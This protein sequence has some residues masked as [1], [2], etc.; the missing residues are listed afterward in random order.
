MW[1]YWSCVHINL[2]TRDGLY[3]DSIGREVPRYFGDTFSNFFQAICKV[4][5]KNFDFIKSTQVVHEI[6]ST[7]S[8]R[9]CEYFCVKNFIIQR[10]GMKVCGAAAIFSAITSSDFKIAT[11]VFL[12]RKMTHYYAWM[13]DLESYSSFARKLLLNWYTEGEFD[14]SDT[15]LDRAEVNF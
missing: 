15:G 13:N 14:S 4:C 1:D 8:V 7:K 12:K 2:E 11:E 3:T 6:Q 5:E 9:T 10:N